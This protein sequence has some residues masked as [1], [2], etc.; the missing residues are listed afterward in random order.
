[1][2]SCAGIAIGP[3]LF[4]IA[5]LGIL[6]AA[7]AAGSGSFTTGTT[8]EGNRAKATAMIDMGQNLKIGFERILGNGI[9]FSTVDLD[10]VNTTLST[11][12]FS[13]LG[14]G[15][16]SPSVS[17]AAAPATDVWNY[18]LIAIPAI[19]TTAGSRVAVLR[20]AEG[21][22]DEIN[23]KVN[24]MATGAAHGAT[25][26]IGDFG[27]G[28]LIDGTNWPGIFDGKMIGC[29][30]NENSTTIAAGFYFYQVLGVR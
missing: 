30:E 9:D 4:I 27:L 20:V 21:V 5:V 19:G 22:C 14:G 1:M 7:I 29:V 12:L 28:T 17:M 23:S 10:P 13:P 3:I 26:D 2:G 11:H 24:T 18:P 8:G 25:D 15:I 6:A 16:T